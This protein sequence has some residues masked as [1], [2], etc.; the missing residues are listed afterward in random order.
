MKRVTH[1][2]MEY[3]ISENDDGTFDVTDAGGCRPLGLR[4]EGPWMTEDDAE[5]A[6]LKMTVE[7][8]QE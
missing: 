7:E 3:T 1:N 8:S 5:K 6:V 2:E 4:F